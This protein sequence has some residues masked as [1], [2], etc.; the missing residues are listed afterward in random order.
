MRYLVFCAV[1]VAFCSGCSSDLN[2]A[3]SRSDN[4]LA[5]AARSGGDAAITIV[6]DKS[7]MTAENM[8]IVSAC[9]KELEKF[10]ASGDASALTSGELATQLKDR[11][12]LEYQSYFAIALEYLS[13]AKVETN[14][15]VPAKVL[16]LVRNAIH[17]IATGAEYW[18]EP[19]ATTTTAG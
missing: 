12:P 11:I 16:R 5:Y 14:T 19:V 2:S 18:I 1:I 8:A 15:V 9:A 13:S 10:L 4:Y 7:A 6:A 3:N 17:G